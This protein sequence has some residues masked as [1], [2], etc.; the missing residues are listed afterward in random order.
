M[1]FLMQASFL[2]IPRLKSEMAWFNR[3]RGDV[4]GDCFTDFLQDS[5][6]FLTIFEDIFC[7]PQGNLFP[8]TARFPRG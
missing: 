1:P 8:D 5:L 2:D 6:N 4:L 7:Q 3:M